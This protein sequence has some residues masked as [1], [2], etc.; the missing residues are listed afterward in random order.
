MVEEPFTLVRMVEDVPAPKPL[1][2]ADYS[3]IPGGPGRAPT[4]EEIGA[5]AGPAYD[6]NPPDYPRGAEAIAENRRIEAMN[7]ATMRMMVEAEKAPY[8]PSGN[9]PPSLDGTWT[10]AAKRF[11]YVADAMAMELASPVLDMVGGVPIRFASAVSGALGG[12]TTDLADYRASGILE[13]PTTNLEA[14]L[15]GGASV[16]GEGLSYVAPSIPGA[17]AGKAMRIATGMDK[18]GKLN[19]WG[20]IVSQ[21]SGKTQKALGISAG[22]AGFTA[23]EA[24][25]G[26][27][28]GDKSAGGAALETLQSGPHFVQ[29]MIE[30]PVHITKEVVDMLNDGTVKPAE[31]TRLAESIK[32]LAAVALAHKLG[33]F[34]RNPKKNL[35]AQAAVA[36]ATADPA[37]ARKAESSS[38]RSSGL[39]PMPRTY[40]ERFGA[41][42]KGVQ[43]KAS[44]QI[45]DL[46]DRPG[47]TF[48][49]KTDA[50]LPSTVKL[51]PA[52]E[53]A[54]LKSGV[55]TQAGGTGGPD[56]PA[57][58]VP[59]A[60]VKPSSEASG[61]A[62]FAPPAS[63]L[64]P[65]PERTVIPNEET[66]AK[67]QGKGLLDESAREPP[68]GV[69][70][71][72]APPGGADPRVVQLNK[73]AIAEARVRREMEALPPQQRKAREISDKIAVEQGLDRDALDISAAILRGD[74]PRDISAAH[75]GMTRKARELEVELDAEKLGTPR[76]KQLL[77]EYDLLTRASDEMGATTGR[78]LA[79]RNIGIDRDTGR[80]VPAMQAA[81]E[82]NKGRPVSKETEANISEWTSKIKERDA[83]IESLRKAMA[84]REAEINR[85][86][87]EKMVKTEGRKRSKSSF[88]GLMQERAEL[89]DKLRAMGLRLNDIT[90]VGPEGMY[91]LGRLAINHIREG[92]GT[93]KEVVERMQK[94]VPDISEREVWQAMNARSPRV[95]AK[96]TKELQNKINDM[97]EQARLLDEIEYA[98]VGERG[99]ENRGPGRDRPPPIP[100]L[101]EQLR[102]LR[103]EIVAKRGIQPDR[104]KR[105]LAAID[106]AQK[107]LAGGFR[108]VKFPGP[109]PKGE[110]K[111]AKESLAKIRE[112]IRG[113]DQLFHLEDKLRRAEQGLFDEA[114][115]RKV[116][117]ERVARIRQRISELKRAAEAPSRLQ[118]RVAVLEDRLDKARRGV[119]EEGTKKAATPEIVKQLQDEIRDLK[120][121]ADAPSRAR[122]RI[123]R[124]ENLVREAEAGNISPPQKKPPTPTEVKTLQ[125]KLRDL[126][127]IAFKSIMDGEKLGRTLDAIEALEKQLK[128]GEVQRKKV[129]DEVPVELETAREKLAEL[130]RIMNVEADIAKYQFQ[131]DTG[132][133]LPKPK[134]ERMK[135]PRLIGVLADRARLK[136]QV[137]KEIERIKAEREFQEM[138]SFD[139]AWYYAGK[140]V[141]ELRGLRATGDQ[142]MT[143]RQGLVLAANDPIGA[144]KAYAR[145]NKAMF[146]EKTVDEVMAE[147]KESP[148]FPLA[149]ESG[150]FLAD[151]SGPAS[152][153]NEFFQSEF[154]KKSPLMGHLMRASDRHATV[155]L[156]MLR[157]TAFEQ[158]VRDKPNISPQEARAWADV[159]NKASGVGDI[160]MQQGKHYKTKL[161]NAFKGAT[162]LFFSPR[163]A[164]SRFQYPLAIFKYWK[165][166]R[167]RNAIAKQYAITAGTG[168][169]VLGLAALAGLK[170]GT[171]PRSS[172]F[173]KVLNEDEHYDIWGGFQQPMR[174]LMSIALTGKD[175]YSGEKVKQ[176]DDVL[177]RAYRFASYKLDPAL[178]LTHDLI[179]RRNMVGDEQSPTETMVRAAFPLIVND[180]YDA[181]QADQDIKKAAR[182][183]AAGNLGVGVNV[184]EP[185]N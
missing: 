76:Y 173:L 163:F 72:V 69:T 17:M 6:P 42:L 3:S 138:G 100:Q 40:R 56:A 54:G 38:T 77:N 148:V 2:V 98:K 52:Q 141:G 55:I 142:S 60:P 110:L 136:A 165:Y 28:R 164:A 12:P 179:M 20:Q 125:K 144:A 71:E 103:E 34:R 126:R 97:K 41:L 159:I 170:I 160:T 123:E 4:N 112:E 50:E 116:A 128:T 68:A 16:V 108:R 83:E 22:V 61:Q 146:R 131:I 107:Q 157:M 113:V 102:Q 101:K 19:R 58:V 132:A 27:L 75:A 73:R 51:T 87:A 5:M 64:T 89:K 53:A 106:S 127:K 120:K 85:R 21:M 84:E 25:T 139:K 67:G 57:E 59:P 162:Y 154:I 117:P 46:A 183:G 118:K 161:V 171:D 185:K 92:A 119:F 11:G 45:L 147:I 155:Y 122:Q 70:G 49:E 121:R 43:E 10:G 167:V 153:Q 29:A 30:A 35:D 172:D 44:A 74:M 15:R 1:P 181:Y 47:V 182:I 48:R 175:V 174:L 168:M 18:A 14:G 166:P 93:L 114:R 31:I 88:E 152:K 140:G 151:P 111:A 66:Q 37:T 178:T 184:Y 9:A 62:A 149:E 156:N 94:D 95:I 130:R 169:T 96:A 33:A 137:D 7:P 134:I 65:K 79:M 105:V 39:P 109:E 78:D 90:G 8:Y 23:M 115:A 129:K 176:S 63:P 177:T 99:P 135:S 104:L 145:A 124:L 32:P 81:R 26:A 36:V 150:L 86:A 180:V 82:A 24:A 80:F 143:L 91:L 13:A 133:V 158:F